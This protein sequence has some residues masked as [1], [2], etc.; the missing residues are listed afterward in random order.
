MKCQI[1]MKA[2]PISPCADDRMALGDKQGR[3]LSVPSARGL[4]A[5]AASFAGEDPRESFN[6]RR[7]N[8][9]ITHLL[10]ATALAGALAVC[11][12]AYA[13]GPDGIGGVLSGG[14]SAG[15]SGGLGLDAA[16]SGGVD[17]SLPGAV[18]RGPVEGVNPARNHAYAPGPRPRRFGPGPRRTVAVGT[19]GGLEMIRRRQ[20]EALF[21]GGVTVLA[22]PDAY[23]YMDRQA[24][25]LRR[26]LSGTG[27][28]VVREGDGIL[29][30]LPT[31][32]TFAFDK[33]DIRE[34]FVPVLEAVAH[35]L[36]DYPATYVDVIG[37]TDAVGSYSYNQALSERRAASVAG[38]I[39]QR[40][41]IPAR[42][43]VAGRGK[44][45]PI[46]SNATVQ[47]RAANRRVEI[48]LH[49]YTAG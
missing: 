49:P 10:T 2:L 12:E 26:D 1:L 4:K 35:T 48:L 28:A 27:V 46:E 22:A 19:V 37:H 7:A 18:D 3:H 16:L 24:E 6:P 25:D 13:G 36:N 21:E 34:R 9:R 39:E 5:A 14:L 38:F 23:V 47:G 41:R 43:Y 33:S 29:L 17:A 31:D 32:V 15:L 8:M 40:E 44:L 30:Q 11:G 45:E 20:S 42:L